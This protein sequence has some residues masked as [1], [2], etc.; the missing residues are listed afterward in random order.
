[1]TVQRTP[2]QVKGSWVIGLKRMLDLKQRQ[3]RLFPRIRRQPLLCR[4]RHLILPAR[5]HGRP[6]KRSVNAETLIGTV[7]VVLGWVP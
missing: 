4:A 3:Q 6:R 1:M 2:Q 7:G 5:C